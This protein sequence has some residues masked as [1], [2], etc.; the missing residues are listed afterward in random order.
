METSKDRKTLSCK[1]IGYI[2]S[3]YKGKADT[4]KNGNERPDTEAVIELIDEY[5]EGMADMRPGEK[6]IVLFWFDRSDNVEMTVP[7]HGE[8]PMTGLFSTHAPARPN[9]I[10]VST[11]SVTRIDGVK[12]YF[13]GADMFDGT[14]V[15]DIKSA[16]HD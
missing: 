3:P 13:T 8:G 6:F 10:G 14:P 15:L 4:P 9:P 11:I 2:Y 7:F 16:G 5:K 1:P 12:I